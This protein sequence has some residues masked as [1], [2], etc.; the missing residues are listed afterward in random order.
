MSSKHLYFFTYHIYSNKRPGRQLKYPLTLQGGWALIR[1]FFNDH[2]VHMIWGLIL[3]SGG[4]GFY[5]NI[6]VY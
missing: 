1:V 2:I 4:L 6:A 5:W 3:K